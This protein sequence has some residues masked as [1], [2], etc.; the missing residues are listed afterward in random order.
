MW[1]SADADSGSCVNSDDLFNHQK[2]TQIKPN[3]NLLCNYDGQRG[4]VHLTHLW[5]FE[6]I[7]GDGVE[8]PQVFDGGDVLWDGLDH[9]LTGRQHQLVGSHLKRQQYKGCNPHNWLGG[10]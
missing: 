10:E 5:L 4:S 8:V 9:H 7:S 1:G 3:K 6:D 2:S